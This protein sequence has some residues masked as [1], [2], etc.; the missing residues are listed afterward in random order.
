[1]ATRTVTRGHARQTRLAR[2][3]T[4]L[5][6]LNRSGAI[7][8]LF[9]AAQNLDDA[10]HMNLGPD[11]NWLSDGRYF[12]E[13]RAGQ[14]RWL[15]PVSLA[16]LGKG[17]EAGGTFT[18]TVR[19]P[20]TTDPPLP[21]GCA[22]GFAFIP[23]GYFVIGDRQ[24]SLEP[25]FAWTT[26]FYFGT[27]EVTNGEFRR[28]LESPDGY[29]DRRNWTEAGR[30]ARYPSTRSTASLVPADADYPRFGRDDLPVVLVSWYEANAYGRWLTRTFGKGKLL[31]RMPTEAEWEKAA[32]GPDGFDYGLGMELSE[33]QMHLYNWK[34]N[35]EAEVSLP[36]RRPESR[37]RSRNAR[38]ARRL[39]VQRHGLEA[40]PRLPGRVPA[41]AHQQ[42]PRIPAR[43]V[44]AALSADRARSLPRARTVR[45]TATPRRLRDS[46]PV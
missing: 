36:R 1:L 35:P 2:G 20:A 26:S 25:H 42:R 18:I 29:A 24:N 22:S 19:S 41:G 6:I 23:A 14:K 5:E 40:R 8:S 13:A 30:T 10:R 7:V 27:F 3:E 16:G 37:R 17:R 9:R 4:R 11:E 34:K 32:R 46:R 15:F 28:F 45:Q 31:Y 39:V 21:A 12:V 38:Y 43:G 44:C 33:P